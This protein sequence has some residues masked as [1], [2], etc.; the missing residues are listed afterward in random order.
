MDHSV[1]YEQELSK[2]D[3][4]N[5]AATINTALSKNGDSLTVGDTTFRSAGKPEMLFDGKPRKTLR[6]R[7]HLLQFTNSWPFMLSQVVTETKTN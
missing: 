4:V 7:S 2:S 6:F 1:E 5:I 3:L